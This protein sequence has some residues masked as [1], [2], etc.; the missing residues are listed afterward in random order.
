MAV[1]LNEPALFALGNPQTLDIR[2][3][4]DRVTISAG[5]IGGYTIYKVSK[6]WIQSCVSSLYRVREV[7]PQGDW[8]PVEVY[9]NKLVLNIKNQESDNSLPAADSPLSHITEATQE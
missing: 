1:T 7:V 2:V 8:I 3:T 5:G 6:Y 4:S 9:Q